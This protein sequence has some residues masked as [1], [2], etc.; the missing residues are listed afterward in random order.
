MIILDPK[1]NYKVINGENKPTE[2]IIHHALFP[3]CSIMDVHIW[4][5]NKGWAGFG[6]Q[7]YIRRDGTIWKGRPENKPGAHCKENGMNFKSIGICLEGC[8]ESYIPEGSSKDLGQKDG[9]TTLQLKALRELCYM[10]MEKYKLTNKNIKPHSFY[11]TYK[12]CPGDYW[13]S[14]DLIKALT[15]IPKPVIKPEEKTAVKT[16][17][18]ATGESAIDTLEHYKIINDD[19]LWKAKNLTCAAP[20][21][22]IFVIAA[23][24]IVYINNKTK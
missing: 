1:L 9:P 4:H 22:L 18:Q 21:W 15:N 20:L 13:N 24:I 7:Y 5:L 3:S 14:Y 12:K 8:Y 19:E 2:I 6:Y 17:E 10:L 16:W 11:A 23:R